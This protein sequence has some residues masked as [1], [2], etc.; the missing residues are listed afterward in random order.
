MSSSSGISCCCKNAKF[1][2]CLTVDVETTCP[3]ATVADCSVVPGAPTIVS[4]TLKVKKWVNSKE[5]CDCEGVEDDVER[6][7][8]CSGGFG[9]YRDCEVVNCSATFHEDITEEG[10]DAD[11]ACS[12]A[13][14][15][16]VCPTAACGPC[17]LYSSGCTLVGPD[18]ECPPPPPGCTPQECCDPTPGDLC[19]C[20]TIQG[21]ITDASCGACDGMAC[22]GPNQVKSTVSSCDQCI[23]EDGGPKCIFVTTM[24][25]E[26][27]G[28][29]C[30]DGN[31][32]PAGCACS[33]G[34]G[35]ATI[36]NC[37]IKNISEGCGG[38]LTGYGVNYANLDYGNNLNSAEGRYTSGIV[39]DSNG[40]SQL[41]T[42][43]LFGYGYK[44]L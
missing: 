37:P 17:G 5:E 16:K 30:C 22:D 23:G 29:S 31:C 40:V 13:D 20:R 26:T 4:R 14:A 24:C 25:T 18:E 3:T 6:R 32:V 8:P 15:D 44:N 19:C 41:N 12:N 28:I 35:G 27:A 10:E 11:K 7:G 2:C 21:C 42:L 33:C 43:L 39:V 1:L 36:C 38:A 34:G 9:W